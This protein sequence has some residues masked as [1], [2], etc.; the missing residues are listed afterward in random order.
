M[1]IEYEKIVEKFSIQQFT[2]EINVCQI[3]NLYFDGT[4]YKNKA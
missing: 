2:D 3:F 1:V 4:K